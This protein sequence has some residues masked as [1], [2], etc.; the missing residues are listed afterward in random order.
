ML[1]QVAPCADLPVSVSLNETVRSTLQSVFFSNMSIPGVVS[2]W[3]KIRWH[4]KRGRNMEEE[5]EY[6]GFGCVRQP[7]LCR[8]W[9][10]FPQVLWVSRV[11][12]L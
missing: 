3:Q 5:K 11:K 6:V 4:Q 12:V 1:L 10:T 9:N 2:C 7:G 8:T